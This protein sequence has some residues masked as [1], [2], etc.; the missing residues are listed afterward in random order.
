MVGIRGA[1]DVEDLLKIILVLVIIWIGLEI[2]GQLVETGL[3][4]LGPFRGLIGLLI[5]VL[6][7]LWLLDRI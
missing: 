4:L 2:V 6:I 1:I 3:E 5:L 7:V